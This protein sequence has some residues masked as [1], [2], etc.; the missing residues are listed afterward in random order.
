MALAARGT[1]DLGEGVQPVEDDAERSLLRAQ[2]R[3]VYVRSGLL[4]VFGTL[5]ILLLPL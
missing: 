3:G 1:R 5:A 4:A 2:A